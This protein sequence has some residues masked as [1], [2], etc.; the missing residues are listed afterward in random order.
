MVRP[1]RSKEKT[2]HAAGLALKNAMNN[3]ELLVPLSNYGYNREKLQEGLALYETAQR[4]HAEQV[5]AYG[6]Q[7]TATDKVKAKWQQ[8]RQAYMPLVKVAS[9]ALHATPQLLEQLGIVVKRH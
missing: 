7:F 3:E 1:K 9:I 2:L 5:S 8:A 4:L 6:D